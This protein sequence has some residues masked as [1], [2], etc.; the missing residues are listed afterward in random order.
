MSKINYE[1]LAVEGLKDVLIQVSNTCKNLEIDF[2]IVGAI[3][4]NIWYVSNNENPSGTKDVDFGIYVPDEKK[5]N[6]LRKSLQTKFNY[7][8][9]SE[10]AFC[11]ITPEG[12]PIDLLPFGEI[13]K[14]S[15]VM[16][17]GKGLTAVNLDGFKEAY[18]FGMKEVIIG[19][20]KYKTCSIPG[21]MILK[22]IAFD[23]R[24]D[25]RTK[26]VKDINSI[27]NHYPYIETE[28]IWGEYFD[29]YG[30][31]LEHLEVAMIVLGREMKKVIA[32][33]ESLKV[34]IIKIIE[35]ALAQ[36]TPFLFLMI[37]DTEIETIE[38]KVKTLTLLKKGF[39]N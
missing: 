38:M 35:K 10:N 12:I 37:E 32:N 20:E 5:Y 16:I 18:I 4:R 34:R 36:K 15:Q 25:Q 6:Q 8:I 21:V 13:E 17:D 28:L 19:H 2:F 9:S 39:I 7:T 11:L 23:D 14:E 24:P 22:M 31:D 1:A 27:C 3:A 26:D 29:L 33:N 30:D